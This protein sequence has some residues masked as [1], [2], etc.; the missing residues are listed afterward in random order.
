MSETPVATHQPCPACGSSD[1]AIVFANGGTYC[2]SCAQGTK[3]DSAPAADPASPFPR[4][5]SPEDLIPVEVQAIPKRA[6]PEAT[7][8]KFGYG[9]G[10]YCGK[11]AQVATYCDA[12]GRP[13]AQKIRMAGKRFVTVGDFSKAGLFGAHLFKEGGKSITVTEGELDAL[14]M[15]A[16]WDNRWPVVSIPTGAAAAAGVFKKQI[17]YLSKFEKVVIA[18]DSDE[19]GR[20]AAEECAAVLEP[21]KAFIVNWPEGIKDAN[22][23]LMAGRTEEIV[24]AFWDA[25]P[26]RPDGLVSFQD[27]WQRVIAAP[28]VPAVPLQHTG[29]QAKLRGLRAAEMT[30]FVA[31]TGAGKSTAVREL[32]AHLAQGEKVGYIGLEE[33]IE[34]TAVGL[35]SVLVSQPLHLQENPDFKSPAVRAA[36][37]VLE[38]NVILYDAY[39]SLDPENLLSRMRFMVVGCGCKFVVLDHLSIVTS[40]GDL[41][42]DERRVLDK[43]VTNLTSFVQATKVHLIAVAHLSRDKGEAHEEGARITLKNI[44]GSHG[45]A[46]AFHNIIAIERDQQAV[47]ARDVAD[48]RVLKCRHTGRTGLAGHL[49]YDQETGR[50]VECDAAPDGDS[51]FDDTSDDVG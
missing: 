49:K 43:L 1:A 47:G 24:R 31:G 51:P 27:A 38:K 11:K 22:D 29:L 41:K 4:Q 26:W 23:L 44:R 48:V 9:Y 45:I 30:L 15:S 16:A 2:Y 7:A 36:L 42:A 8:Q 19:Q 25:K 32:A 40:G 50:Q 12:L 10:D 13:V 39:G 18:F 17:E 35:V 34:R 20:K 37:D 46:Q 5:K 21:G 14:S 3:G 6:I 28:N 33:G